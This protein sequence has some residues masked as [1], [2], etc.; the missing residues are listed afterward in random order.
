MIQGWKTIYVMEQMVSEIKEYKIMV[1]FV[2]PDILRLYKYIR[3]W[4][5]EDLLL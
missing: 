5:S 2:F 1:T 4:K 3:G